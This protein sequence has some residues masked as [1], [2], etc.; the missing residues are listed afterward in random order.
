MRLIIT[1]RYFFYNIFKIY[2]KI[3]MLGVINMTTYIFGHR[4]PD[5]DS[6]CASIALSYLKNEMGEKTIPKVLGNI[7]E[8]TRF[9]LDFF[10][11]QIPNYL[12]DVK[13]RIKNIKYNKSY[14][15]EF[16]SIYDT[17]HKM[18]SDNVT[19]MPIVDNNKLLKGFITLRELCRFLVDGDKLLLDTTIDNIISVI[20]GKVINKD[21]NAIAGNVVYFKGIKDCT[22]DSNTIVVMSS[23]K[24]IDKVIQ[25]GVKLIIVVTDDALNKNNIKLASEKE[26]SVITTDLDI[27]HVYALLPLSNFIKNI[28]LNKNPAAISN[29]EYY[30]TF[31]N[32]VHKVNHTN[33]PVVNNKN[34]C[35]GLI[36]LTGPNSYE[37]QKV[38]MVDHN[39]FDQSVEGIEEAEILEIIDHHNLGAIGTKTPI[40][41][42]SKTVGATSTIIYNMYKENN[43]DVPKSMAGIM[44]GAILSDTFLLKSPTTTKTDIEA[45]TNLSKIAEVN[46]NKFGLDMLKAASS[47]EGKS[48]KEMING[49]FKNYVVGKFNFG[50]SQIMTLDFLYIKDHIEEFV[51]NLNEMVNTNYSM[52]VVFVTDVVKNGSYVIYNEKAEKFIADAFGLKDIYEGIFIKDMVSRKKQMLPCIMSELEN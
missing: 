25:K 33:Y 43:V 48:V 3:I 18:K 34:E 24:N 26:V 21:G 38:I 9:V 4:N 51:D 46:M 14:V 42:S 44:L 37:K 49:D 6:V 5:T 39:N 13:I 23:V 50:I 31:R 52:V 27:L 20:N 28:N 41:F 45:A 19:A 11:V 36:R 30:T 35:L 2:G 15:N 7:N 22:L 32:M 16:T 29:E 40:N 10:D 17:Y 12:N 8:E 47:V 1:L